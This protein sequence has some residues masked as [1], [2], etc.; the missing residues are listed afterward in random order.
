MTAGVST[1]CLY[2]MPV[3]ESLYQLA[4]N[5][6]SCVEIFINSHS[7]LKKDFACNMADMLKRFDVKCVSVHPF[8]C[9][10][11]PMMFFSEYK[12]RINDIL[13]YYRLYFSFMNTVGADIFVFHGAKGSVPKELCCERYSKLRTLGKEYGIEVAVENVSRCRSSS[14]SFIRDMAKILG[15]EFSFVL[16]TKQA[17]RSGENPFSFVDAAGKC[18]KHIHIS[19]SGEMGDC[20]PIGKGSFRFRQFF[21]KVSSVN[22][23]ANIILELYRSGFR[24]ISDLVSGYNILANMIKQYDNQGG[25]A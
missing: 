12:R 7:E 24:G 13:E 15:D 16:D 3:E 2:P 18:L 20:L 1:A 25:A 21:D 22:P 4:V 19:D 10:I 8:T 23:H 9:D 17:L 5:G 6:I 14:S 11:E